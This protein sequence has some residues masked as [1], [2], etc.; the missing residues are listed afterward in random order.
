MWTGW[1]D[2]AL[3]G[4]HGPAGVVCGHLGPLPAGTG[5]NGHILLYLKHSMICTK[6]YDYSGPC[7]N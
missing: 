6:Y 4:C 1:L 2:P 3:M 5:K 7:N